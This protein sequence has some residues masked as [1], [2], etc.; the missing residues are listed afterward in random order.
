MIDI[1]NLIKEYNGIGVKFRVEGEQLKITGNKGV[2]DNKMLLILKKYKSQIIEFLKKENSKDYIPIKKTEKKEYYNLSSSQERLYFLQQANKNLVAYNMPIFIEIKGKLDKIKLN[3]AIRELISRHDCLR[4]SFQIINHQ[5]KQRILDNV[6]VR[7]DY[8]KDEDPN[9]DKLDSFVKPFDLGEAPLM[10]LGIIEKSNNEFLLM[11]DFHH[12][13]VDGLSLKIIIEDIVHLYEDKILPKI[14][15]QYIDYVN[16]ISVDNNRTI[17][18]QEKFW[19]DRF[20]NNIPQLKLPY[21]HH[22]NVKSFNGQTITFKIN[23][24]N[25]D[26][27]LSMIND[28]KTTLYMFFLTIICVFLN[29]ITSQKNIILGTPISGRNHSDFDKTV[30]MFVNTLLITTQIDNDISFK[31]LLKNITN[32]TLLAFENSD[33]QYYNLLKVIKK[34]NPQIDQMFNVL[35]MS[36]ALDI[37]KVDTVELEVKPIGIQL[38]SAKFDLTFSFNIADIILFSINYNSSLFNKETVLTFCE[39]VS[40]IINIV[41][42][43]RE[44]LIKDILPKQL[45]NQ[46]NFDQFSFSF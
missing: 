33:Y 43:N 38:S 3:K 30:G 19:L 27:I 6:N 35:F 31:H 29:K 40:E 44:I 15:S 25:S 42:E 45:T 46:I 17:K 26:K 12:I 37:F 16:W 10:Q 4:T 7:I 20:L 18:Q 41:L 8:F 21:D 34:N 22:V 24:T 32:E 9:I 13:V 28:E 23:K 14:G 5:V 1:N 2:I 36:T 39:I 11:M